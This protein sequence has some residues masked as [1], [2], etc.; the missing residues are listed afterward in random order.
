[1]AGKGI[2]D[3]GDGRGLEPLLQWWT[4]A[5]HPPMLYL[6]YVGSIVPFAFAMASLITHQRGEAGFTAPAAGQLSRGYS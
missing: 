4:M 2:I 3:V 5:I 6:G 1:M